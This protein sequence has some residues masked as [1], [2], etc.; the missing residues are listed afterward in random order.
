MLGFVAYVNLAITF[1]IFFKEITFH[2]LMRWFSAVISMPS[3]LIS[4]VLL[5]QVLLHANQ[6]VRLPIY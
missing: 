1:L 3:L 4:C 5:V 6:V 2:I